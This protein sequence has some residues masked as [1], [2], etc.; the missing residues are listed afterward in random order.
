MGEVFSS[1]VRYFVKDDATQGMRKVQTEAK[2][3]ADQADADS[4]RANVSAGALAGGLGKVAAV[5]GAAVMAGAAALGKLGAAALQSYAD[6]E[7]LVGGVETLFG[8]RGAQSIEEYAQMV[9]K[10][11]DEVQGEYERNAAAQEMMMNNAANAYKTAGMSANE[12][13][14]TATASAAAMVSSLG[15]DTEKAAQLVDMSVTDMADN[16][17]KMGTD[18][19]SIQQ[20]YAGFS[21]QNYTMLDNLSIAGAR[22]A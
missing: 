22:A 10:S 6:Y 13:M 17:N 5:A 12:Y 11:V 7:Q 14:E 19:T 1:F 21:K 4:T 9:G 16:A 8:N 2:K 15:G 20:A 18:I 3:T